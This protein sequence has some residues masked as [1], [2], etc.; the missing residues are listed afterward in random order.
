M[1]T[2][3]TACTAIPIKINC[4]FIR[5]LLL[6][7]AVLCCSSI[8][9]GETNSLCISSTTRMPFVVDS[10]KLLL[11]CGG[12][13]D[14]SNQSDDDEKESTRVEKKDDACDH[15]EKGESQVIQEEEDG[16]EE[17]FEGNIMTKNSNVEGN[18]DAEREQ[19]DILEDNASVDMETEEEDPMEAD[20]TRILD[21]DE[22]QTDSFVSTETL[23][24]SVLDD[25]P[26]Q[27]KIQEDGIIISSDNTGDSVEI[28]QDSQEEWF[29]NNQIIDLAA[30]AQQDNDEEDTTTRISNGIEI[31]Y[32]DNDNDDEDVS[33]QD[34]LHLD[35]NDNDDFEST[36]GID[37]EDNIATNLFKELLLS[38]IQEQS[39]SFFVDTTII[40]DDMRQILASLSYTA[41]EINIMKPNIASTV[42][43]FKL[44]RPSN[45]MP[46]NWGIA[47]EEEE[48]DTYNGE[49]KGGCAARKLKLNEVQKIVKRILLSSAGIACSVLLLQKSFRSAT[50][51]EE[52]VSTFSSPEE[53]DNDDTF[54]EQ[55]LEENSNVSE[56]RNA[57][58]YYTKEDE[59]WF[60]QLITLVAKKLQNLFRRVNY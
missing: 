21:E 39:S 18:E 56:N 24:D 55:Q 60:D 26:T 27:N 17:Q 29:F 37:E 33:L 19:D 25:N 14:G 44:R 54:M 6:A 1:K 43:Q 58:L 51:A 36:L 40:T 22:T 16:L 48:E 20:E 15:D 8:V 45:G 41:N 31:N 38:E 2:T 34:I 11:R 52:D 5:V 30:D 46:K 10:S 13:G 12:D 57:I 7:L 3:T 23:P 53:L 35:N 59:T 32:A 50:P 4:H 9:H 42:I 49:E 28:I 47:S